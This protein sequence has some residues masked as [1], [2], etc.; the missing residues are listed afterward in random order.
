MQIRE[1]F[2]DAVASRVG[3]NVTKKFQFKEGEFFD[4]GEVIVS[5]RKLTPPEARALG[6][7]AA[8][9]TNRFYCEGKFFLSGLEYHFTLLDCGGN[10]WALKMF[11]SE[12]A[13]NSWELSTGT[14]AKFP[15]S[16][17]I[18]EKLARCFEI[19]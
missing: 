4:G 13:G 7:D 16:Q 14:Y 17:E 19:G 6:L 18:Y 2:I 8:T 3:E 15:T 11:E 9:C 10:N 1:K 5:M 12:A